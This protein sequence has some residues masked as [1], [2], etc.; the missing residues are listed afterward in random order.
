[1]DTSFVSKSNRTCGDYQHCQLLKVFEEDL[2]AINDFWWWSIK[3]MHKRISRHSRAYFYQCLFRKRNTWQEFSR[4]RANEHFVLS[5]F[6]TQLMMSRSIIRSYSTDKLEYGIKGLR[7]KLRFIPAH[8][9]AKETKP[10]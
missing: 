2:M 1:M 4:S 5:A 9:N 10:N 7:S 6:S 3:L 8:S